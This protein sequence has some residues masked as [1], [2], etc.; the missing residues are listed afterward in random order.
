MTDEFV[1]PAAELAQ[2]WPLPDHDDLRASL[3]SAYADPTRAYHDATHLVEV[4][5]RLVDLAPTV[6]FDR[7]AVSLAAWFHD[8]VYRGQPGDEELAA[9]WAA[10]ALVGHPARDEVVR[11]V[12]MTATHDPDEGDL[13]ACALSDADLAI[14]AAPRPRYEEYVDQVRREYA[15]VDDQEFAEGRARLLRGLLDKPAL[16][17]CPQARQSW[18]NAARENVSRE[19]DDLDVRRR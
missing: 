10:E 18:E 19:L 5:E 8:A 7:G 17:H 11:L 6:P 16:F 14:L 9:Q 15:H 3:Q 13:N 4:F 1:E 12:R 2:W